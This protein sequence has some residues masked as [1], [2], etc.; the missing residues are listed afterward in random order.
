MTTAEPI[1]LDELKEKALKYCLDL[2]PI[3]IPY[4]KLKRLMGAT[5]GDMKE[6]IEHTPITTEP[7]IGE[8]VER[9]SS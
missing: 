7:N 6:E 1:A 2:M 9:E 8:E 4:E 3:Q 5:G